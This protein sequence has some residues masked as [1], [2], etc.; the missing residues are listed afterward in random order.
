[1]VSRYNLGVSLAT[2][3]PAGTS[4]TAGLEMVS[5]A[6]CCPHDVLSQCQSQCECE[7]QGTPTHRHRIEKAECKDGQHLLSGVIFK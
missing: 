4:G 6:T 7:Q 1:M 5:A 2:V 3:S